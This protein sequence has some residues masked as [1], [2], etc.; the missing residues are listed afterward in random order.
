MK[1]F[2]YSLSVFLLTVPV[3]MAQANI[4][5]SAAS[6]ALQ[7][8]AKWSAPAIETIAVILL[9]VGILAAGFELFK[10][11]IGWSIGLFVGSTVVFAVLWAL[12]PT[13]QTVL[14]QIATAVTVGS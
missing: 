5:G 1:K 7:T 6:T 14:T 4:G 12:A 13:V 11:S 10:R 2:V 8:L 3:A 9:V